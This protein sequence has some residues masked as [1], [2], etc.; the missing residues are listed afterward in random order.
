M[1][2]AASKKI[3]SVN[4]KARHNYIIEKTYEAGIEL[5][6][7]EVKSLRNGAV[8]LKDSYCIIDNGQIYI[9]NMHISPY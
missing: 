6:G 3:I 2:K 8:N 7:T 1:Q 5:V 4:R 9:L